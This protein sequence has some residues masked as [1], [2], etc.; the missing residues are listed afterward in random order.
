MGGREG[1]DQ[2]PGQGIN[3]NPNP[4]P[5]PNPNPNPDPNPNP[6]PNQVHEPLVDL[7]ADAKPAALSGGAGA[8]HCGGG[9][10]RARLLRWLCVWPPPVCSKSAPAGDLITSFPCAD[11]AC[12]SCLRRRKALV[13]ALV[14]AFSALGAALRPRH[15]PLSAKFL[16]A[17]EAGSLWI[18]VSLLRPSRQ[19]VGSE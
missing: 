19:A 2:R 15:S 16:H 9:G 7:P 5:K 17:G 3:P 13:M 12:C 1:T 10:G 11:G 8:A 4:K 6:N 14:I 18:S